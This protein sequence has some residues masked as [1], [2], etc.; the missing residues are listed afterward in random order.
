MLKAKCCCWR[1]PGEVG[2]A[3]CPSGTPMGDQ[4]DGSS[5]RKGTRREVGAGAPAKPLSAFVTPLPSLQLAAWG[6]AIC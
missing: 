3:P 4:G 2:K 5:G 1:K 6:T